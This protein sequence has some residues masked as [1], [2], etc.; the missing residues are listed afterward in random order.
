MKKSGKYTALALAVLLILAAMPVSAEEEPISQTG[1]YLDTVI[2]ITLYGTEDESLIEGA[3]SVISEHEKLLSRTMEGSD[4]WEVNHSKGEPT[5]VSTE[6]AWLIDQA[7][8]IAELTDGAFDITIAPL[9]ELW[10]ITNNPGVLPSDEDIEEALK[11]VDYRAVNL[12][13]TTV[14]LSDP[15]AEI[16]L[17]GIA[18]GYIADCAKDYLVGEGV[19]HALLNLGGDILAVG[20]K[21]D[22]SDFRVGIQTPFGE[23]TYDLSAVV[24]CADTSVVTSGTYERYFELDGRI[25]HHILDPD[26]GAPTDNGLTSVTITSKTSTEGDALSTACFVLGLDKGMELVES[27]DGIEALFMDEDL[28]QYP[29]S[30]FEGEAL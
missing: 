10:D 29:S 12:D 21:E 9:I 25:Y 5:E 22:G 6:T 20:A 18:K 15:E 2:T 28:N 23:S 13:G 17:G 14:T 3:F 8:T 11:H 19:E 24:E 16:D 1:F 27:M 30:G 7:L 4:V 26:T